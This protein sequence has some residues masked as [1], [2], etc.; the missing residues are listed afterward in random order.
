M[1]A[2]RWTDRQT[3]FQL[4]IVDDA[5]LP[6]AK[7]G[8]YMMLFSLLLLSLNAILIGCLGL[9]EWNGGLEHWNQ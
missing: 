5:S 1:T 3:S 7:F 8:H 9:V 6:I 2:N 4:Y